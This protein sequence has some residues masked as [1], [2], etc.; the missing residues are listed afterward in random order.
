MVYIT[1][2]LLGDIIM[3]KKVNTPKKG[4]AK[5]W[6]EQLKQLREQ[7]PPKDLMDILNQTEKPKKIAK[8]K[9]PINDLDV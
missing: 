9:S 4:A 2:P 5:K 6:S 8:P 1:L 3:K 7:P